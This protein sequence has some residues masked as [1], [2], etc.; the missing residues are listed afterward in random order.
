MTRFK[1]LLCLILSFVLAASLCLPTFAIT[2][3]KLT[4]ED[5]ER[6]I[7]ASGHEVAVHGMH[8]VASGAASPLF[9]ER[10]GAHGNSMA[11]LTF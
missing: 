8:H 11:L 10:N 1:R 6:H 3:K 9:T 7:L 4:A 2:E 5:I